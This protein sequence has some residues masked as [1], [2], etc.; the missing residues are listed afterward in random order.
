MLW[1]AAHT[2]AGAW[3]SMA[4]HLSLHPPAL[5]AMVGMLHALA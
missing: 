2:K 5:L 4:M 3:L 1:G